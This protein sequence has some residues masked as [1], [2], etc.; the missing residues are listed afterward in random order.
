MLTAY[1]LPSWPLAHLLNLPS[2]TYTKGAV[3]GSH[4]ATGHWRAAGLG[5]VVA[6]PGAK[7]GKEGHKP[8]ILGDVAEVE[9][10]GMEAGGAFAHTGEPAR[11]NP[12]VLAGTHTQ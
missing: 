6:Q 10:D 12:G 7:D 2:L 3:R 4:V 5:A 11:A 8:H 9:V 1:Y